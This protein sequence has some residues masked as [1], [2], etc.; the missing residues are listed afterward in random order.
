MKNVFLT[1][2]VFELKSMVIIVHTDF[3]KKKNKQGK[4]VDK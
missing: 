3:N 2:F 4:S 1:I